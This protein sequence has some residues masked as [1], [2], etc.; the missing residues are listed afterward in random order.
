MFEYIAIMKSAGTITN[1]KGGRVAQSG[2]KPTLKTGARK[3]EKPASKDQQRAIML[4]QLTA[5]ELMRTKNPAYTFFS[6]R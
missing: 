3:S 6:P 2:D 4:Q 1:T 5:E